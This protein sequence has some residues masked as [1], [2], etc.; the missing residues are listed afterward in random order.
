MG[1]RLSGSLL[2]RSTIDPC[3]NL[4]QA[5]ALWRCS[6]T[7]CYLRSYRQ[8]PSVGAIP[9]ATLQDAVDHEVPAISRLRR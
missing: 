5:D 4:A 1:C 2:G 9:F 7:V 3:L 6:E 8:A